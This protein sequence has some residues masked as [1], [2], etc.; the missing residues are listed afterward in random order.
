MGIRLPSPAQVYWTD[1]LYKRTPGAAH[2]QHTAAQRSDGQQCIKYYCAVHVHADQSTLTSRLLGTCVADTQS[3]P[4][5]GAG[6]DDEIEMLGSEA[7][8]GSAADLEDVA[9]QPDTPVAHAEAATSPEATSVFHTPPEEP[10]AEQ[11]APGALPAEKLPL[12]LAEAGAAS[13]RC[14]APIADGEGRLA[15]TGLLPTTV[16]RCWPGSR[17]QTW[18]AAAGHMSGAPAADPA[19]AMELEGSTAPPAAEDGTA[20]LAARGRSRI[21]Q[22][23][24]SLATQ[25]QTGAG[26]GTAAVSVQLQEHRT[27]GPRGSSRGSRTSSGRGSQSRGRAR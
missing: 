2:C 12:N 21:W 3:W 8:L 1:C 18:P 25:Q 9:E 5:C 15:T 11:T 14:S 7:S 23:R 4:T 20:T 6:S 26:Q 10:Q 24:Q 19:A 17:N 13:R 27:S 16:L 22:Q